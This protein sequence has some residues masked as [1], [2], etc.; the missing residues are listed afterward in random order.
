M[1]VMRQSLLQTVRRTAG[2]ALVAVALLSPLAGLAADRPVSP[3][4]SAAP[5]CA[6]MDEM[7]CCAGLKASGPACDCSLR[8]PAPLPAARQELTRPIPAPTSHTPPTLQGPVVREAV[9]PTSTQT[10]GVL[11]V[12][13]TALFSFLLC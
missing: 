12:D 7:P 13:R 6:V 5:C 1:N 4:A 9:N 2:L 11:L 8:Q 3:R 10:G